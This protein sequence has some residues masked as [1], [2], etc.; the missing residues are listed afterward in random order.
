MAIISVK[1]YKKRYLFRRRPVELIERLTEYIF[2]KQ[3]SFAYDNQ[4][5]LAVKLQKHFNLDRVPN[6]G[7]VSRALKE[8]RDDTFE[9]DD[10]KYYVLAKTKDEYRFVLKDTDMKELYELK[11]V[12]QKESVYTM[13]GKVLVFHMSKNKAK[14]DLFIKK[15]YEHFPKELFWGIS[16]HDEHL[17]LMFDKESPCFTHY[18]DRFLN[19]FENREAYL[20]QGNIQ[21]KPKA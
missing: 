16:Q 7:T 14:T 11:D 1:N 10:D 18:Y 4:N 17:F 8:I 15:I 19:F 9:F 20:K 6:Q 3:T 21:R 2:N 12:F 13:S 5:D